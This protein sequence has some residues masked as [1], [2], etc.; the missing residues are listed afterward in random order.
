MIRLGSPA[1]ELNTNGIFSFPRTL[2]ER[3]LGALRHL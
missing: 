1:K 2:R 3:S